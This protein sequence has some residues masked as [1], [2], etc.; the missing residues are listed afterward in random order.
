MVIISTREKEIE[1]E[2]EEEGLEM[3]TAAGNPRRWYT[4]S[5]PPGRLF[6]TIVGIRLPFGLVYVKRECV[7]AVR[8]GG[9]IRPAVLRVA[10]RRG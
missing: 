7:C 8:R 5:A 3:S 2:E 9:G 4:Y 6:R 1:K 10:S